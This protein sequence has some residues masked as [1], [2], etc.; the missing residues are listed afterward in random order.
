LIWRTKFTLTTHAKK[1]TYVPI[2]SPSED[3]L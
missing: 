3:K 1:Y 2:S